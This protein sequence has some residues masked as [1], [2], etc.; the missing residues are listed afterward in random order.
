MSS[1]PIPNS[2]IEIIPNSVWIYRQ[3]WNGKPTPYW[4]ARIVLP[5]YMENRSHRNQAIRKSTKKR[6]QTEAAIWARDTFHEMCGNQKL[7]MPADSK[8]F[9]WMFADYQRVQELKVRAG[10]V[11]EHRFKFNEETYRNYLKP[12]FA[13]IDVRRIDH[14][15]LLAYKAER[16]TQMGMAGGSTVRK[17]SKPSASTLNRENM[18]LRDVLKHAYSKKYITIMPSISNNAN[19]STPRDAFSREEWSYMLGKFDEDISK[20]KLGTF[21]VHE[22][23]LKLM[24]KTFCQLLVYSG[25]REGRETNQSLI[26]SD[27]QVV[28]RGKKF[29]VGTN[30]DLPYDKEAIERVEV[31]IRNVKYRTK[32]NPRLV[33]AIPYLERALRNWRS[34]TK[35]PKESDPIF[36]HQESMNG[37]AGAFIKTFRKGFEQFLIRHSN[38]KFTLWNKDDEKHRTLYSL[39]HTYA[40]QRLINGDLSVYELALNMGTSIRELERTYS[41]ALPEAFASK[42]VSGL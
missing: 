22:W 39:R 40:T 31:L 28:S 33:M 15:K 6:N 1:Q 25:A 26:W 14:E 37:E 7:G 23:R 38:G 17:K 32:P 4:Y 35:F 42:L 18:V 24:M 20:S 27:I 29:S 12:F 10:E 5:E 30:N 2:Q 16:M 3:S 41:K 8:T 13:N 11:S 21:A 9:A 36:C 19:N 34:E